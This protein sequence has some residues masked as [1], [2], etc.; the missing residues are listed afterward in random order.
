MTTRHFGYFKR[1]ISDINK[2]VDA[3]LERSQ[4]IEL[5]SIATELKEVQKSISSAIDEISK[6]DQF[7]DAPISDET[8]FLDGKE[9][10]SQIRSRYAQDQSS[11]AVKEGRHFANLMDASEQASTAK[12]RALDGAKKKFKQTNLGECES[13]AMVKSRLVLTESNEATWTTY[14]QKYSQ[15]TA[16]IDAMGQDDFLESLS[17]LQTGCEE[18]KE[19]FST[20]ETDYPEFVDEFFNLLRANRNKI[21]LSELSAEQFSWLKENGLASQYNVSNG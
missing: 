18:I 9:A 8:F 14:D 1:K 6:L 5:Q 17:E 11:Q 19:I 15:L 7:L 2:I 12:V 13:P 3:D 21:K 4:I 20:F 10:L 16:K